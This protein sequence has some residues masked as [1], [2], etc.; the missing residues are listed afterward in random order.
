MDYGF[1]KKLIEVK[2]YG[3]EWS[4]D[5]GYCRYCGFNADLVEFDD[6]KKSKCLSDDEKIIK[7][8]IE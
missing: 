5:L 6:I 4:S 1:V 7:D 2:K 3:H 8:I